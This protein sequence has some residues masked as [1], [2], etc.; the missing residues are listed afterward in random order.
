M[1]ELRE[2]TVV[3]TSGE[4]ESYILEEELQMW[5]CARNYYVSQGWESLVKEAEIK[6]TRISAMLGDSMDKRSREP[7]STA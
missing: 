4:I 7:Y 3:E 1:T 5:V 2:Q 6:I